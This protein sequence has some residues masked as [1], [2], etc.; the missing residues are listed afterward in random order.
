MRTVGEILKKARQE[1]NLAFDEI[2]KSLRIRKKFLMALEENAWDKLPSLPYIKGFLKNYSTFLGLNAEEMTAIFRRQFSFREK[3]GIMPTGLAHPL[4]EPFFRFTPSI[5]VSI[6]VLSFILFFFGYLFF[7]YNTYISPPN[8]VVDKPKEGELFMSDRTD[9]AG[10]SDIDAVVSVNNLKIASNT[11]GE[12]VTT[13]HLSP[14]INTII[15]DS[16]S[17]YGKKKTITRTISA[18][19]SP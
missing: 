17:K 12:F 14:G 10:K 11:K 18:Q 3:G 6:A 7:Q 9:V 16:T 5:V 19:T 1:K 15:I 4:N 8:L 2:E 13:V